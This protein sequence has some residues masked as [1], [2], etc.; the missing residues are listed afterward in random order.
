[1]SSALPVVVLAGLT[2]AGCAG[3]PDIGLVTAT[4]TT[5]VRTTSHS[6]VPPASA[7]PSGEPSE[8]A[9]TTTTTTSTSTPPAE[10]PQPEPAPEPVPRPEPVAPARTEVELAEA[11]VFNLTNAERAVNGCPALAVDERLDKAARGHSADMAAQNYFDHKSKDGR[12]F[13]DRVKAA[14]YPSPGAENIAA[15]Q[16]TPEAVVKGWMESPGH[17]ANMLNCKLKTLGVGMARG[18]AYGIY[19]TQNFGW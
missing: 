4:A 18:G 17:R 2:L 6:N 10:Q 16:R 5:T 13:V 1:M 7:S 15:G 19:W 14:G 3:Q 11:K 9:P 12:T 8:A